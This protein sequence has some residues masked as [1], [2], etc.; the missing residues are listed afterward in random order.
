VK[1]KRE[2]GFQ[3]K[4]EYWITMKEKAYINVTSE[5]FRREK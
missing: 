2:F 1:N 3:A 5:E 4:R